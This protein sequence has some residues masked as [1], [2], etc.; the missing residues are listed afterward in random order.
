ML[1][2]LLSWSFL[3]L[4]VIH[5]HSSRIPESFSTIEPTLQELMFML[6]ALPDYIILLFHDSMGCNIIRM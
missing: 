5:F 1:R 3:F 2:S 6:A 4:F